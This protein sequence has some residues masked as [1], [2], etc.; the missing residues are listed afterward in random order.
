MTIPH[1]YG[2]RIESQNAIGTGAGMK[3]WALLS[4]LVTLPAFSHGGGL[5]SNGGHYH[6]KT[7]EYHCHRAGCVIPGAI[8]PTGT[9]QSKAAVKEAQ[10]EERP[11]SVV[12][13]RKDWPHWIDAD[14]DCQ[15]TRAEVLIAS[16]L[17]LVRYRN[18]KRCSVIAGRWLDPYS[19]KSWTEASDLDID[20]VITV[21]YNMV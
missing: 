20:H 16:S 13:D 5:N 17:T 12:Y 15:D 2:H 14:R 18:E 9:I 3:Y 4:I 11:Y 6:R 7:G 21:V 8:N 19:G 1:I 10:H